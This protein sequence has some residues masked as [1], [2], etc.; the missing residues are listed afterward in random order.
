M[1]KPAA[2]FRRLVTASPIPPLSGHWAQMAETAV[3]PE[4]QT[5]FICHGDCID[6]A[7]YTASLIRE[8]TGAKTVIINY[9]GPVIGAHTG[10]GVVGVSFIA[11]DGESPQK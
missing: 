2:L 7:E 3:E 8:K 1:W 4:E 10:P 5:V 11:R 9:V 6:D